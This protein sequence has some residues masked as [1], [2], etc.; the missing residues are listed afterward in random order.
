MRRLNAS[1]LLPAALLALL[2]GEP[3]LRAQLSTAELSSGSGELIGQAAPAWAPRG[4]VNS[5]P[6][7]LSQARG[8]VIL[9]RFFSDQPA[10]A[11]ALRAWHSQFR[12]Q[13]L[14]VVGFY[15]PTPMSSET[16][17]AAVRAVA[18][19]LGFQF[20]VGNDSQ[21][22]TL[23]RYW[24]NRADAEPGGMTFLIDR[25][26]IIRYIQPDGRYDRNAPD[27]K[28]RG[29]FEKMERQIQLLLKEPAGEP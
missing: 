1:I 20:P 24:L 3:A 23:N 28:A 13:G 18:D 26:G 11:A 21:W 17:P 14:L 22:Q 10:G 6:L 4:W 29:E 7:E 8:K 12:E 2:T 27:R 9:L 5:E 15:A 16:A 25:R 19:A